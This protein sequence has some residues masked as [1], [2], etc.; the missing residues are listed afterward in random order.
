M[1]GEV[2][3]S[4]WILFLLLFV[5]VWAIL[6][7]VFM[8]SVRWFFRR[9]VN[10]VL[11]EISA[12]L[13]IEIRPFQLT[14]RQV[15]IDRLV[16]DPKVLEAMQTYA[17]DQDMPREVAQAEVVGYAKEIVPSFNAYIYFRIG[18]WLAKKVA[19]L[20]YWVRVDRINNEQL[21][22]IDPNSTVVFVINHRSNMDYILVSFLV[23]ERTALSYAAGE[24]ARIWPLQTLL[25]ATGAYFVRRDSGS[26]PLYRRVLE[27]YVHMATKEGVCQAVFLEG[28]LSRDGQLRPPKLGIADYMLRGFEPETDRDIVFI[29]VGLNYDRTL[30]DRSLIRTL[31]PHAQK[32]SRWFVCKTTIGFI[33]HNLMLMAFNRW[34]RFGFA[35]VNFGTPVS[36]REFSRLHGVNLS[37][38]DRDARF[39]LVQKLCSQLMNAVQD[40]IPVLPVSLVA[41]VLLQVRERWLSD[42]DVKAHVHRLMEELQARGAPVYIPTR[43]AEVAV[44]GAFNMLKLRRMVVES[45]ERFRA[46]PE[47]VDILSYYAN[48]MDHWRHVSTMDPEKSEA[49]A[50]P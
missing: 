45:D 26:N 40:N 2:T 21:A 17:R 49:V 25:K 10:R 41:S 30:E 11:D 9:R 46:D 34:Q 42:F 23:A 39:S 47:S 15:L 37:K 1:T 28:G 4:V 31:D 13:D 18:Y 7:R 29:P 19:R 22:S 20:L 48:A 32:R 3:I 12:R 14:K 38:I 6:D 50:N 27:R 36:A 35:C 33:G 16:Y 24:W 43:G 44:T 5:A 8:P